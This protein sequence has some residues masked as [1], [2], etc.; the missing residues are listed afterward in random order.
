M[1]PLVVDLDNTL[2]R[3]D[4]LAELLPSY[5]LRNP[6]EFPKAIAWLLSG[7]ARL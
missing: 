2:L 4:L 6:G 5:L 1:K 3:T 7:R